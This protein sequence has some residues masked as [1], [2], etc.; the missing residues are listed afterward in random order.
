LVF[1]G[2]VGIP[3][4]DR[5]TVD[6]TLE[7]FFESA[8]CKYVC[9][10]ERAKFIWLVRLLDGLAEDIKESLGVVNL[11][12]DEKRFVVLLKGLID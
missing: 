6:Q 1:R 5:E 11:R 3:G 9:S 12:L 2:K 4:S 10:R 7:G 8:N